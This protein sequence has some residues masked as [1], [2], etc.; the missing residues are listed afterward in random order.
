M[1]KI[2]TFAGTMEEFHLFDSDISGIALPGRLNSPFNYE[3]HP[4]AVLAAGQ[5]SFARNSPKARCSVF[6]WWW[7]PTV[8]DAVSLPHIPAR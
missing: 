6:L 3:P 2:A 8:A 1:A 4:L 5:V 7:R